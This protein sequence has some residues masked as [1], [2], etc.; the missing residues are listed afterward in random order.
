LEAEIES[1]DAD[2]RELF[3]ALPGAW[4]GMLL[5][6]EAAEGEWYK[7]SRDGMSRLFVLSEM[8]PKSVLFENWLYV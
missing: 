2:A 8:I 7:G 1:V 4:S 6:R 3:G 5:L